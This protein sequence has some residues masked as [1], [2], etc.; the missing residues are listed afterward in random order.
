MK[1]RYFFFGICLIAFLSCK[2]DKTSVKQTTETPITRDLSE[3]KKD[4]KL[5]VLIAYSGTSY[6]LYRGRPM[7]YEYELLE[8]LAEHLDLELEIIISNDLDELLTSLK[9]GDADLV[10]YGLA[11][12]NDRKKLAAFTDYLYVTEQVLVQKKPVNWRKMTL[13]DI[14]KSIVQNPLELIGDTVSVRKNTSYYKRLRNLS[15]EMGGEIIIDTLQGNLSTAEIIKMVVD[16]KIKYTIA[17]KNLATINASYFPILDTGVPVSFSQRIAWAVRPN[18]TELLDAINSWIRDFKKKA[19]YNV[20]YNKYFKNKRRF[21]KRVKSG[22]YSINT[23]EISP[24]DNIIKKNSETIGW[25]WRLIAALIY[26]ESRFENEASAWSGAEGLMQ[27]MPGT[28]NDLGVKDRLNPNENIRGGVTY[29]KQLHDGHSDIK[30]SIER[31]KFT[32]AAYNCG[33]FHVKDA[34]KLAELNGLNPQVW[35]DNVAEMILALSY[36]KNY[37]QKEIKY[38]YVNGLEPFNYVNDI[39]ERYDHYIKFIKE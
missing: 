15:T 19:A 33:Y 27:M 34:Q 37:T 24:Y 23:N 7:G 11:I 20:L 10:A 18:A 39:F 25:D 9:A 4:G 12:T 8:H 38:G 26:Q 1:L 28:A 36:P 21:K 6:F 5:K 13:D 29:L 3:I 14:K 32:L 16:G 35:N 2:K 17:D 30:D 22:F 31:I